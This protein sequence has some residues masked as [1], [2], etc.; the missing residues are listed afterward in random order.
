MIVVKMVVFCILSGMRQIICLVLGLCCATMILSCTSYNTPEEK[1]TR[2]QELISNEKFDDGL[3]MLRELLVMKPSDPTVLMLG[4]RIYLGLEQIDSAFAYATKLIALYPKD[5][6]S[7]RFYY[8]L[9]ELNEDWEAQVI[10]ISRIGDMEGS[11]V[12][13]YEKIA[14]LNYRRGYYGM[15]MQVL[16]EMLKTNP[17]S[18]QALFLMANSMASVGKVDSAILYMEK[19]E[20]AWPERIEVL[21]NMA[22]FHATKRNYEQA[23][24][25]FSKTTALYPDYVPGWYGL[26]NIQMFRGDTAQGKKAYWQAYVRDPYFLGV[27][28]IVRELGLLTGGIK[29]DNSSPDSQ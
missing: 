28:S 27:D 10:A 9:C 15:A 16:H 21:S 3:E 7:L 1:I 23:E 22:A 11:R 25:Y 12:P 17:D 18:A 26:G 5:L 6:K 19:L 8:S 20:L 14:E 4:S 24:Y 2:I 29:L 13:Y